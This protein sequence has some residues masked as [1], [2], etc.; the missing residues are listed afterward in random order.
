MQ[1]RFPLNLFVPLRY[2]KLRCFIDDFFGQLITPIYSIAPKAGK[3]FVINFIKEFVKHNTK[4]CQKKAVFVKAF[5]SLFFSCIPYNFF[6]LK[7]ITT[8]RNYFTDEVYIGKET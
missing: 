7:N 3:K 6:R 4:A 1:S 2:T 5:Q 8:R